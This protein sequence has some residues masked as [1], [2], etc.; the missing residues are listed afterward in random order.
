[1]PP[2]D[3]PVVFHARIKSSGYGAAPPRKPSWAS[4]R[5]GAEVPKRRGLKA[6]GI[7]V[8]IATQS[9]SYPTGRIPCVLDDD[10][11]PP[12]PLSAAGRGSSVP[13]ISGGTQA[14]RTLTRSQATV[15]CGPVSS[16]AFN[17][18]GT[19]LAVT[20][21]DGSVHVM[22]VELQTGS[23]RVAVLANASERL[24]GS[25]PVLRVNWSHRSF[26]GLA[27]LLRQP[28]PQATGPRRPKHVLLSSAP[29]TTSAWAAVPSLPVA[30]APV[31][32]P[33]RA[34]T[35]GEQQWGLY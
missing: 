30:R 16:L 24:A 3:A 32:G 28:P 10:A 26:K 27:Q 13:G 5:V 14:S 2:R 19:A 18:R 29:P 33:S 7:G 4:K 25:S 20:S 15:P 21:H 1:M 8:E 12:V 6:P 34:T 9:T 17:P 11:F 23:R 35:A 22:Q 31:L